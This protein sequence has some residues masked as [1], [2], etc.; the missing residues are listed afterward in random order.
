MSAESIANAGLHITGRL[1]ENAGE[2]AIT[3]HTYR[4]FNQYGFKN[5]K[6]DESVPVNS[7]TTVEGEKNSIIGKHF[8]ISDGNFRY[9]DNNGYDLVIVGVIDTQFDYER[10]ADYMPDARTTTEEVG[11]ED[12]ILQIELEDELNYGFHSL[13]FTTTEDIRALSSMAIGSLDDVRVH[14]H[15]HNGTHYVGITYAGSLENEEFK[16]RLL[17][18]SKNWIKA[19]DA[20]GLMSTKSV[21]YEGDR[22]TYSFR[23]QKNMEERVALAGGNESFA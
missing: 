3:E 17:S 15:G 4:Q 9:A 22:Y 12:M 7:L 11:I 8:T 20:D 5:S 16:N 18:L 21:Y 10:Y 14:M 1:P 2:I 6:Y 19:Y 13:G 23:I